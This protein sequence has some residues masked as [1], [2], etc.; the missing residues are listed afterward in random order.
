MKKKPEAKVKATV[1][2]TP[3]PSGKDILS[4]IPPK[5]NY[6]AKHELNN[7]WVVPLQKSDNYTLSYIQEGKAIIKVGKKR[8]NAKKGDIFIYKPHEIHGGESVKNYPYKTMAIRIDFA[9]EVFH[10][11]MEKAGW[12]E[13]SVFPSEE[14]WKIRQVLDALVNESEKEE[15]NPVIV[16]NYLIELFSVI[17]EFIESKA[18]EKTLGKKDLNYKAEIS[19]KAKEY[20]EKNFANKILL[21]DIAK[22]LALSVSRFCHIFKEYTKLSPIDYVIKTRID[23]AKK[24]LKE[25]KKNITEI[26]LDT[27]F[28]DLNYFIRTFK[29][30]ERITP[31]GY[32]KK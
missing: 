3:D 11:K 19:L 27:G 4:N 6:L 13:V 24:L 8:F 21:K 29:K 28:S 25:T 14:N 30:Q 20:I 1:L 31:S 10:H 32:R 7:D 9:D 23:N 26:A 2:Y 12:K 18:K 5:L 22:Q 16:K 17:N 15:K